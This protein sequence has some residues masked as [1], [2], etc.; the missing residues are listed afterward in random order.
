MDIYCSYI[1]F[2]CN[3][4]DVFNI[5]CDMTIY[6]LLYKCVYKYLYIYT[7]LYRFVWI[8][9]EILS[10]TI[11]MYIMYHCKLLKNTIISR[12]V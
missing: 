11:S 7:R 1:K 4:Y 3:N 9:T 5:I 10:G 8:M 6:E 12:K 2:V